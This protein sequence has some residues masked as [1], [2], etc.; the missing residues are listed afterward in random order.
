MFSS[1]PYKRSQ[2]VSD[3]LRREIANIFSYEINDP[4]LKSL[5]VTEVLLSDDL[6]NAKIYVSDYINKS[7]TEENKEISNALERSKSYVKKKLGQNMKIKKLPAIS[8]IIDQK[9]E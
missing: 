9:E 5:T 2:R 8:F 1:K 6:S 4:R 7:I 3:N